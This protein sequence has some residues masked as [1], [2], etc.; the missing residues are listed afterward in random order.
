[1]RLLAIVF[2]AGCGS[3]GLER[4][5]GLETT[6]TAEPDDTRDDDP[7]VGVSLLDRTWE[8]DLDDATVISPQGLDALLVLM[9]STLL[10]FHVDREAGAEM[11]LVIA[12][13]DTEGHQDLCQPV[14]ELTGAD[15]SANPWLEL[16]V[17]A[18]PLTIN[19]Q[20]VL[21]R[22]LSFE[23]KVESY[24]EGF[25]HGALQAEIDGRELDEALGDRLT[26]STCELLDAM[27]TECHEC[28][29]GSPSCF[30]LFF[31]EMAGVDYGGAFDS[32]PDG[33]GCE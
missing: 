31:S 15:W 14:F 27:G 25:E 22:N 3:F 13:T 12:L 23:M 18:L 19:G 24:G 8:S 30:D 26:S 21:L 28:N 16:D 6:E 33:V 5:D 1:M 17:A 11:D 4:G 20:E 9:E 2:V 29:D 10:L 32:N 7:P